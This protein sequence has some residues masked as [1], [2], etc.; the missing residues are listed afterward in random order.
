M[1][2]NAN[3]FLGLLLAALMLL[4]LTACGKNKQSSDPNHI[5]IGDYELQYKSASI[6]TDSEGKDAVV[7][8][9]DFTNNGKDTADYLWS[10]F[11]KVMQD[12]TELKGAI[13]Y[14][15]EDS[16]ET[17]S[18]SQ[19]T[20]IAP[21]KTIEVR[22]A[23]TLRDMENPVEVTFTDLLEKYK[24][25]ITVDPTTLTREEAKPEP[26]AAEPDEPM[27]AAPTGDVLLDWW[28]GDWY[29]WWKVASGDG[30]YEEWQGKW[31]DC[32]ANISI[33]ADYTGNVI[34]W[35]EDLPKDDA[36]S[37]AAVNL[38]SAGTGEYGTLTSESGYFL[39][40]ELSHAD[41]IVDPG[42]MD[43]DS[44]ICIDGWYEDDSGSFKYEIYLR[45]WGTLWDDVAADDPDDL[46]YSYESWYLPLV[47]A[48][49]AMPNTLGSAGS[50][51]TGDQ[52]VGQ[53]TAG[54]VD[55]DVGGAATDDDYGKS[56]ANAMGIAKLEDM[57]ALYKICFENRSSADHLFNYE[58][59]K[60][61][62]GCDG[63]VWKKS[64]TSWDE[65]KH[66]YRWETEDG[67][68]YFNISFELED[69]DEWY[70]SCNMSENVINGLW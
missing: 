4:G 58:D 8:T 6:M 25:T 55:G 26:S 3:R 56:N 70:W 20:E 34:I 30:D 65:T 1:K 51:S 11:E 16:Y 50:S 32:C 29:G 37:A 21:G 27:T 49:K 68:D 59:A 46:P 54:P 2:N 33:G 52:D 39:D 12:G 40:G 24:G 10:I 64:S 61:A 14:V 66:T 62:L 5:V 13:V 22:S 41:W 7:L 17:V 15:S 18:D 42:L 67:S 36:L 45:P 69:G 57:Q 38:S 63:V 43:Y 44:L 60:E 48:G 31:W 9:M 47:N 35:D 23:Y 28:N 53:N 19:F